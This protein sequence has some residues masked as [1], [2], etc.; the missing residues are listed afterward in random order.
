MVSVQGLLRGVA[1]CPRSL[2]RLN[3]FGVRSLKVRDRTLLRVLIPRTQHQK[4]RPQGRFFK[5]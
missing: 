1:P 2:D 5:W 4:N 3:F